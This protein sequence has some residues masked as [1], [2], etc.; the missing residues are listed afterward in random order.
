MET[1]YHS[2]DSTI[3]RTSIDFWP[4]RPETHGQHLHCN[5]VVGVWFGE[6]MRPD[7]DM[8][9][10]AHPMGAF[11]AAGRAVSGGPV[12]VSDRPE[13]HD[14]ELLRL[15]VL[16][17]GTVLRADGVGRPTRDCLFADVTREP[18]LLKVFNTN[19][20]CAVI[21]IFNANFHPAGDARPAVAG[22]VAPCDVPGL[23][24]GDFA[25]FAQQTGRVWRSGRT[26]RHPLSLAEGG[27]EIVSYAPIDRGVAVLGL[28]DKLNS[29]GAIAVKA[30]S[31][32]TTLRV[33]LRDGGNL[34]AWAEK[35]PLAIEAGGREIAFEFDPGSG[36]L[37]ASVPGTG[38]QSVA[39]RW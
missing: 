26:D 14:F 5:A 16:S 8:F 10:S 9:Q 23:A 21:G 24:G 39:L 25:G 37:A 12:Y 22:D 11:H 7:W 17:D 33:G 6:F 30:W 18:V 34:V 29:S 3:M 31:G 28:A 4:N 27:W 19:R 13:A 2:P 32:A 1:Y 35:P 38:P 20:D 15:L 36:R